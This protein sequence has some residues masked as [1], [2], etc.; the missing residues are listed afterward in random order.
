MTPGEPADQ[1]GRVAPAVRAVAARLAADQPHRRVRD[2]RVEDADRVRSAADAGD[3][4]VRQPP[5]QLQHLLPG[6]EPDDPLE[7]AHHGRERVRAHDRADAVVGR[8]DGGHP[9]AE[10]LVDGVLEGPAARSRPARP[11]RRAAA[12]GRRSAPAARC[13]PRPCRRRSP[14]RAAHTRSRWPRRAGR[15]RS[16]RSCGCLPIRLAS[17]A[18]PRTL[19]I[20]WEPVCARSSR[21]SR[22]RQSPA[23]AANRGTSVTR[24]GRPA[25]PVSRAV[26]LGLELRVGLGRS[27]FA[28]QFVQ[29]GH[30][31]LGREPAAVRAEVPQPRVPGRPGRGGRRG[32]WSGHPR[33]PRSAGCEPAVTRSATA[34][35][36]SLPVTRLSPTSTASAPAAA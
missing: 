3:D 9:V 24:V 18:W 15:R 21:L 13:P 22:I 31:R 2:E 10:R 29:R 16:R 20:L 35:R 28:G 4:R 8:V 25:Y 34:L 7:V 12:S 14:G 36:G 27:V 5:G 11:R 23:R 26:E 30:Q 1:G 32:R 33:S 17:R 6:L 19:L